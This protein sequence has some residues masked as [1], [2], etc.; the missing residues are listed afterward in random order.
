[1]TEFFDFY[2]KGKG[3]PGWII[4]G[5]LWQDTDWVVALYT[6]RVPAQY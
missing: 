3:N 1:M 5:D 4:E 2:L 6:K